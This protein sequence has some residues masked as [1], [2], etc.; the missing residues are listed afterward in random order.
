MGVF[1]ILEIL[2]VGQCRSSVSRC[3]L[4]SLTTVAEPTNGT[5]TD[6][7]NGSEGPVA[8]SAVE[9]HGNTL[10]GGN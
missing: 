6:M 10:Q 7:H 5:Y 9:Q 8:S 2:S 4:E 1:L 3:G